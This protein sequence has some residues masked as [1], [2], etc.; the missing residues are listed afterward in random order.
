MTTNKREITSD[1]IAK[2]LKAVAMAKTDVEKKQLFRELFSFIDLTRLDVRDGYKNIAEFTRSAVELQKCCGGVPPVASICVM[3]LFVESV[4]VALG[5]EP[6]AI[7]S[8]AGAFPMGQTYPEVKVLEC[9]MA[10]E[11]GADEIDMVIDLGAF[12]EGRLDE[13]RSEI[14]FIK[15]EI[16]NEVVLKI[17]LESGLITSHAKVYQAAW[18]AME[19]GADFV[20]T[21]TGKS[22]ISATPEAAVAICW[23]IKDYYDATSLKRGFKV[24]GGVKTA[25]DAQLYY[26]IVKHILGEKWLT[27]DLFRIGASSLVGSLIAELER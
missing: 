22:E 27:P 10:V 4:G 24:A 12:L 7:T 9:A 11:N 2:E 26:S 6:I 1:A 8:V 13:L 14:A 3:P 21:S 16:G 19:G 18:L 5:A 17:I 25:A 15:A 20:K 23:A